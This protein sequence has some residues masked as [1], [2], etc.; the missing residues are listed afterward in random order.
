MT[1]EDLRSYRKSLGMNVKQFAEFIG[2]TPPCISQWESGKH[3]IPTM[4]INCIN[5]LDM[6]RKF[7]QPKL[8]LPIPEGKCQCGC[9]QDTVMNWRTDSQKGWIKGRYRAFVSGH[10]AKFVRVKNG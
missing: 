5:A 10:N 1:A 2:V 8:P 6:L 7:Q 4:A 3:P 9:G